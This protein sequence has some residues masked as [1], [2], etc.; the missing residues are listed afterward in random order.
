M[1]RE[2]D[3]S[4]GYPV[5]VARE[6]AADGL[7]WADFGLPFAREYV[8]A[9]LL[10]PGRRL[11]LVRAAVGGTGFADKHWGPRD[12]HYLN[13]LRMTEA[14]LALGGELK[15]L[16]WHQGETD[17]CFHESEAAYAANLRGLLRGVRVKFGAPGLP[18]VAGDFVRQW[19][20]DNAQA[21][22]PVVAA[23]R[24]MCAAESPAAFVETTGLPSNDEAIQNGDTIH[25]SRAAQY[26]LG[27]RYF[28][29][30]RAIAAA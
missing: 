13:M 28:A 5:A 21:C 24:G 29:A 9:G 16:L 7:A 20:R 27:K 17:A 10:A 12:D 4:G 23:L 15:A 25:F 6:R 8:N 18:F 11:L 26:A 1:A 22:A 30:Y 19:E 14:A 2:V 3:A